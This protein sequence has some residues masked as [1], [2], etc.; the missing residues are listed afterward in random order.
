MRLGLGTIPDT[1]SISLRIC[2]IDRENEERTNDNA[3]LFK[4]D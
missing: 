4:N 3:K 1:L 2:N